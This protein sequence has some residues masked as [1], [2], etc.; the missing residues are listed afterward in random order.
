[1]FDRTDL[2]LISKAYRDGK[3]EGGMLRAHKKA[4]DALMER[5]PELSGLDE[6]ALALRVS[7]VLSTAALA[8]YLEI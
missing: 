2:E 6:A 5:H 4:C 8:H 7:Q 3:A 1:M